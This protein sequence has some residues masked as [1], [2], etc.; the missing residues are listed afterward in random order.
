MRSLKAP[1]NPAGRISYDSADHREAKPYGIPHRESAHK[2]HCHEL[3]S[4][5]G[6]RSGTVDGRT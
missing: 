1:S 2:A 5:S 4:M 3:G 6:A